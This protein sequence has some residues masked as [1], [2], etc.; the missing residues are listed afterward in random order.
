M[1]DYNGANHPGVEK[2]DYITCAFSSEVVEGGL[3]E[4]LGLL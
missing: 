4:S 1:T 2:K 3:L